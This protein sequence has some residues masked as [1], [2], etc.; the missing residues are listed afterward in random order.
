MNKICNTYYNEKSLPHL[1]RILA[2]LK[3]VMLLLI[4]LY[5]TFKSKHLTQTDN[6]YFRALTWL[7]SYFWSQSPIEF[8][9]ARN[10]SYCCSSPRF[11]KN[12][13]D[14]FQIH[15]L[16]FIH[17]LPSPIWR[18]CY[19]KMLILWKSTRRRVLEYH[20]YLVNFVNILY[21]LGQVR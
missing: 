19:K 6:A 13:C 11:S 2:F 8:W 12:C 18:I 14:E 17:L 15:P 1:K 3:L 9:V 7:Q 4:T 20:E 16:H 5:V 10:K 21:W